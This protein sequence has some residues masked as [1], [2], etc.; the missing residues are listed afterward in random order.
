MKNFL[1]VVMLNIATY[2]FAQYGVT[3]YGTNAS[4]S[5]NFNSFFGEAAGGPY[6]SNSSFVGYYAGDRDTGG[7]STFI[8][9]YSGT[10]NRYG[11]YNTF[12]GSRSGYNNDFGGYNLFLGSY[13]G[14]NNVSGNNNVFIGYKSGYSETSSNKLYIENSDS[15]IPLIYGK[16]DTDQI[17]LN[18]INIPLGYTLAVKDKI[19]TEELRVR[20]YANWPDHVF[21]NDYKLPDLTEVEKHI[22]TN[23][24]LKDIPSAKNV[25]DN[26]FL[27]GDMNS[28]LLKKIEELTLYTIAQQKALDEQKQ[29]NKELEH[30]LLLLEALVQS[31]NKKK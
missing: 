4:I 11:Q 17:G 29:K 18:T 10:Y 22:Q 23:G 8:G 14:H 25:R 1:I 7:G 9:A 27:I 19:I 6:S 15:T 5:G 30:R 16:F 21:E 12:L 20:T 2:S 3:S 24:H 28:R 26:G 31:K 13:S